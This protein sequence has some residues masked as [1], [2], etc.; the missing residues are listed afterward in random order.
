MPLVDAVQSF[1]LQQFAPGLSHWR[2]T[3]LPAHQN[4]NM[5][6]CHNTPACLPELAAAAAARHQV[7]QFRSACP[8][9]PG[10]WRPRLVILGDSFGE[11]IAEPL[12]PCFAEVWYFSMNKLSG[13]SLEQRRR[14][15]HVTLE[16]F[17]PD[18]L[19]HVNS[20][21]AIF[22]GYKGHFLD[23]TALLSP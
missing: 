9:P 2:T 23:V 10:Q 8:L 3:Q 20:E 11:A 12:A 13:L 6:V 15:L 4:V 16:L 18:A 19:L 22:L 5:L 1:D 7:S 21:Q 14:L 17:Q